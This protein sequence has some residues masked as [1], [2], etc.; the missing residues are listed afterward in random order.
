MLRWGDISLAYKISDLKEIEV[1]RCD[2][3]KI[4]YIYFLCNP[5]DE[6][7]YIGQTRY[8]V[9]RMKNHRVK[10]SWEQHNIANIYFSI[11]HSND[12]KTIEKK[13]IKKYSPILNIVH[14]G[15]ED[16]KESFK[17]NDNINKSA[18]AKKKHKKV[19]TP[20]IWDFMKGFKD[21]KRVL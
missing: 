14:N 3:A 13:L 5:E 19:E 9:H 20:H 7:L 2:L 15:D 6:I 17:I 21:V 11:I 1:I 8:F 18:K 12:L 4:G 16:S 10:K